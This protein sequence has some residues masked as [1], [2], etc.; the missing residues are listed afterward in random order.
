MQS[1]I[2]YRPSRRH[3]RPNENHIAYKSPVFLTAGTA[4]LVY[5]G[6][7]GLPARVLRKPPKWCHF[8]CWKNPDQTVSTADTLW[9]AVCLSYTLQCL[10]HNTCWWHLSSEHHWPTWPEFSR[11]IKILLVHFKRIL[12]SFALAPK[13]MSIIFSSCIWPQHSTSDF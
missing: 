10:I 12:V 2:R 7:I 9:L 13:Y 6:L 5:S 1:Y 3:L 11:P 8:L 4:P